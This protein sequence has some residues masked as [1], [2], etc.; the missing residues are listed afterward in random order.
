MVVLLI[1]T[2]HR[3]GASR[4]GASKPDHAG[5]PEF[6]IP[7]LKSVVLIFSIRGIHANQSV[8]LVRCFKNR[9]KLNS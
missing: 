4:Q 2:K 5:M 6:A 8:N 1:A 3:L 7:P 9:L